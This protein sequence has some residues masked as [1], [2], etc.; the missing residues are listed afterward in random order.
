MSRKQETS[1]TKEQKSSV[2]ILSLSQVP[3]DFLFV[4]MQICMNDMRA[5]G[6]GNKCYFDLKRF[7]CEL[8]LWH[9]SKGL[10]KAPMCKKENCIQSLGR[11]ILS[12][13]LIG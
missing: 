10:P 1:K 4:K 9:M 7:K 13:W 11:S 5:Q 6:R 3:D 12:E 2:K 8:A